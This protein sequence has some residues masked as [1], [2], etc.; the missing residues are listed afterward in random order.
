MAVT[1]FLGTAKGG[2]NYSFTTTAAGVSVRVTQAAPATGVQLRLTSSAVTLTYRATGTLAG[3]ATAD[4][5]LSAAGFSTILYVAVY[6]TGGTGKI[7]VGGSGPSN[8]NQLWFNATA[9][10]TNI[11]PAGLPFQHGD[12]T[13]K[14]VDGTHKNFRLTNTDG[15]NSVSYEVVVWGT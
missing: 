6:A 10:A 8:I 9:D 7:K 4:I 14:V 1:N 15:V 2:A 5:D 11:G 12:G 13:A 3:A